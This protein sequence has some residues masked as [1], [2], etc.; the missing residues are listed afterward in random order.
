M[1]PCDARGFTLVELLIVILIVGILAAVAVPVYLG[2]S[3]EA[4]TAEAKGLAGSALTALQ[5]CTQFKRVTGAVGSCA[6]S[7]SPGSSASIPARSTRAMAGG[8]C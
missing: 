3:R 2:Y 4:K 7:R 5:K 8:G 6:R 1:R